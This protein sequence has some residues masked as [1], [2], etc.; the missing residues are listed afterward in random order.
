MFE[1]PSEAIAAG[2]IRPII[3]HTYRWTEAQEALRLMSR[4]DHF[5]TIVL[6]FQWGS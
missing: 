5:G 1:R 4:G 2:Q 6:E 3:Q